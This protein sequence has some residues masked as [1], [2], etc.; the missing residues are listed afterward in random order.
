MTYGGYSTA[1][2][3]NEKF[4]LW[5]PANLDLAEAA[6]LLCAGI[7]VRGGGGRGVICIGGECLRCGLGVV[8]L[9]PCVWGRG[10]GWGLGVGLLVVHCVL[11]VSYGLSTAFYCFYQFS[12]V[13]LQQQFPC[14]FSVFSCELLLFVLRGM[15]FGGSGLLLLLIGQQI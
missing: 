5:V 13:F 11:R 3:V 6:P 4:V 7:T 2:V 10:W 12:Q 15:L 9:P 14:F 8:C 1:I